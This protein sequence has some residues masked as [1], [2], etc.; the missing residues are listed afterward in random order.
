MAYSK[1]EI[2][3]EAAR[4]RTLAAAFVPVLIGASLAYNDGNLDIAITFVALIA[5]TLIQ[6][7]TNFANDY[8]D[9]E[10]GA[11]N[12]ERIGF[13][14]VTSQGLVTPGIMLAATLGTMGAA[15]LVG[16]YLVWHAGWV[17]LVIGLLAIFFGLTYTGGPFP[18][19]YNGL[20]DIFVF[21]FFGVI[22]VMAT[23]YVNVLEWSVDS[24][25]ASL[26]VGGLSTSILIINNL[27][28]IEQDKLAGKRTIGVIFGENALRWEYTVMILLA[29]AI[30]PHM[31]YRLEYTWPIL[32]PLASLPLGALLVHRIWTV[33]DKARFNL[34]LE[35]TAQFM[36]LFGILYAFGI[37]L[38]R[39]FSA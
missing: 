32:F 38:S 9:N 3:W 15:F 7:G 30:P 6:I 11:D 27:R 2:W 33:K 18:L 21:I 20:G 29:F 14:R 35:R 24:F 13:T 22:A 1:F 8:F 19:G 26:A 31:Y 4:P 25:W 10:T 17:I 39:I 5:A 34:F 36:T 28:D 16:L 12:D 23:Y 37:V